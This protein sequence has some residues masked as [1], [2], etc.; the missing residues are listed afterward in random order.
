MT[1]YFAQTRID[2]TKVKI[3]FTS[4]VEARRV[5]MSVSVP[6]GVT[7]LATMDGGKETEAY[8]HEKFADDNVS[9][10]WFELSEPVREFIRDLQN[11]KQGLIP[12]RDEAKYM[13]RETAEYASDAIELARQMAAEI[14]N[15]EF[16]GIG[17][18]ID[19]AMFR[20]Q[21]KHGLSSNLLHRLRYRTKKD[22]WA[23]EYLH[24]KA[25]YEQ[26]QVNATSKTVRALDLV[27][28]KKAER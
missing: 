15:A 2:P 10:E 20:V 28:G 25:V 27:A 22:I 4:D 24:L 18:T 1:V 3:G 23:G 7:M 26:R 13:T 17:D 5:N 9:G 8:L 21:H 11:G 6:G 16:K 19:A 14:L 12:F